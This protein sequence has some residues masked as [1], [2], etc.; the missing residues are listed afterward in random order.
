LERGF[1]DFEDEEDYR[2]SGAMLIAVHFAAKSS[3]SSKSSLS[4]FRLK[5]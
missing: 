1:E 2:K 5:N 3:S 4:A